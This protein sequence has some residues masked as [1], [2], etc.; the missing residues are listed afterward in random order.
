MH[1]DWRKGSAATSVDFTAFI[2]VR[3]ST[4]RPLRSRLYGVGSGADES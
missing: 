4:G 3:L 1:T 2:D